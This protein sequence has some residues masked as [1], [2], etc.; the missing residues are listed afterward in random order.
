MMSIK[1][2]VSKLR[3][4]IKGLTLKKGENISLGSILEKQAKKYKEKPLILFEDRSISYKEFNEQ[5]NKYA[6]YFLSLGFKKGD[7][8]ALLM[9]NRPEFL[10]IHA[11][12][13]KIGVVPALLNTNVKGKILS[14]AVNIVKARAV[15]AGHEFIETYIEAENDIKLEEPGLV[16]SEST[17][18]KG[19]LT[20]NIKNINSLIESYSCENPETVKNL[21]TGDLLEY[22]YTSGTTG[23]PKAT[24][25][26]HHKWIQLGYGAG[27]FCLNAIPEDVQY[28][29]LPLYHNS[30]INI[31][32]STS[33]IHGGTFAFRRKFS[34]TAFWDDIRK[35][36]AS[37]FVYIGELCRYL[38][39][40]PL[41]D[42]DYENPLLHILGN[43]MRKDYWL[44]FKN[45]FNISKIIEVYGATEGVGGLANVK[46]E[47]GMIGKLNIGWKKVGEVVKYNIEN[48]EIL[49]D[50]KG[51]AIKCKP[52]ETGMFLAKIGKS[53]PFSG[54]KGNK[55]ATNEKILENVFSKNDRYFISG[56]LFKLHKKNYVS[57]VDR[58]GDTFKWKGEVV[59]TN[60]VSDILNGFENI[61]DCN[62][63][64]VEVKGFEGRC[65]MAA[66]KMRD[67][68]KPDFAE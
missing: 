63:Y 40:Q 46:G 32:W 43:G 68:K 59:A 35:Y 33:L 19:E 3:G 25:L 5:A 23:L 15:I 24:S 56:D 66:L 55:K 12:L 16:F 4:M 6:S 29:C 8:I 13:S 22:I 52:G 26:I 31:A 51:H 28:C 64:G 65:G 57:F 14:H 27:G 34:A 37:L 17:G 48:E 30:G 9:D 18:F 44:D 45:R 50:G 1:R 67:N 2:N 61:E 7:T 36:N 54:Y 41:K 42:N 21:N 60:E 20:D 62:V 10:I 53:S 11:G 58:L 38:N 47:P 39:N 49:R